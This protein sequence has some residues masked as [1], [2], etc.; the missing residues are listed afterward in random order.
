MS[1][2][3]DTKPAD[4][5]P[6]DVKPADTKPEDV[7]PADVKPEDAKPAD[8]KSADKNGVI[9]PI[10][11]AITLRNHHP[12]DSYGR[13]GYRFKKGEALEIPAT[14]LTG[15]QVIMLAE[16]QWLELVPVCAE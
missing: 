16:D 9:E 7:K 6:A 1:K 2:N 5:K 8:T 14:D 11:Y 3:K 13:C 12:Q 4:A 10:A 15:E